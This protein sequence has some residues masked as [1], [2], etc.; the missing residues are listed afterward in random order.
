[1]LAFRQERPRVF[2]SYVHDNAK[3]ID[4]LVTDLQVRGLD[5]WYDKNTTLADIFYIDFEARS[6]RESVNL[7]SQ[8]IF[9]AVAEKEAREQKLLEQVFAPSDPTYSSSTN[10]L[11]SFLAHPRDSATAISISSTSR[12]D[13]PAGQ[14]NA[15]ETY[16]GAKKRRGRVRPLLLVG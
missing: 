2:V 7:L 4:K 15:L 1:M 11:D 9:V 14:L 12:N 10:P 5:V 13:I 16:Q 3:I 6:W 8:A